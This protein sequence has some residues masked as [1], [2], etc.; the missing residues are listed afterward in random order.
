MGTGAEPK[1]YP[2]RAGVPSIKEA[3]WKLKNM[4]PER[5][6]L[7]EDAE[8]QLRNFP[9]NREKNEEM[10]SRGR[11]WEVQRSRSSRQAGTEGR[12]ASMK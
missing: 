11:V 1:P 10:E 5:K 3:G 7:T 4:T 12:K 2:H 8:I 6:S 9:M